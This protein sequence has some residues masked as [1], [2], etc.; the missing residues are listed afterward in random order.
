M[1]FGQAIEI[2]KDGGKASRFGWNG[3]GM[4]IAAQYPDENSMMNGGPYVYISDPK[5]KRFPWNASQQDLFAEDWV[6]YE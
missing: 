3:K 5:G 2:I 6:R 1:T 4:W